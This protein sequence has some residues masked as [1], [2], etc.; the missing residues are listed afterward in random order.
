VVAK[1]KILPESG[2]IDTIFRFDGTNSK[3]SSDKIVE[4]LWKVTNESGDVTLESD[5]KTFEHQFD[6]P[7]T[8]SVALTVS[9]AYGETDTSTQLLEITS[10]KP[11]ASFDW[12]IQ[13]YSKPNTVT[14][15]AFG[16]YDPDGENLAYNW[17]FDG[18]GTYDAKNL[19]ETTTKFT[20][21]RVGQFKTRLQVVDVFDNSDI[22]EKTIEVESTLNVDFDASKFALSQGDE[23]TFTANSFGAV[24]YYWDFDDGMIFQTDEQTITHQFDKSGI[25]NVTLKVFDE[26]NNFNS[27]TQKIYVGY[28]DSPVAVIDY[29]VDNE[30]V[31]LTEDLCGE[32]I[33]GLPV[34]RNSKLTFN[35]SKSINVAGES[36]NLEYYW[37]FGDGIFATQKT[38]NHYYSEL[39]TGDEC[40]EVFLTVKDNNTGVST[41]SEAL[42]IKIQ[43]S[44]PT[45]SFLEIIP[46]GDLMTPV[47]FA[48]NA[49]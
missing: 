14:F 2:E 45:L 12:E 3:P 13:D 30:G 37:D 33:S 36:K 21:N 35:G 42:K 44:L 41:K 23:I 18:D 46:E 47:K 32:D 34:Y 6:H 48:L 4:Y 27:K 8:Y 17:D 29:L 15:D 22:I 24:A 25:F 7:G 9:N 20:F 28:A 43:N 40:L 31:V 39:T 26:S 1:P 10:Q 11:V 5:E 49:R 16:S 38:A 19:T